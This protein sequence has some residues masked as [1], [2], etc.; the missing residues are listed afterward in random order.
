VPRRPTTIL[1]EIVVTGM[2]VLPRP[3]M[4]QTEKSGRA[5]GRSA[6]SSIPDIVSQL[7]QV[8]KVPIRDSCTATIGRFTGSPQ[9]HQ[10]RPTGFA[11]VVF[12]EAS[13]RRPKVTTLLIEAPSACGRQ[14]LRD[15]RQA[16]FERL[17]VTFNNRFFFGSG[18][19]LGSDK[20][21]C[22]SVES[23][24]VQPLQDIRFFCHAALF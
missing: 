14:Q 24:A 4:G 11:N 17:P 13:R 15:L 18:F 22:K 1:N 21:R 20:H 2:F 8:R 3:V 5:T 9:G 6:L 10:T 23:R 16:R 12:R 19:L 7:C